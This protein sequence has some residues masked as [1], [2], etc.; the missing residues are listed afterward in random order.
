MSTVTT[1]GGA[2]HSFSS[3][4]LTDLIKNDTNGLVTVM[5]RRTD[6]QGV[7]HLASAENTLGYAAPTLTVTAPSIA[8]VP[9][10]G[11]A[12]VGVALFAVALARRRHR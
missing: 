8:A 5:L 11:T 1:G 7:L 4:A 3:T 12:A 6:T 10:P 9:E 2:V